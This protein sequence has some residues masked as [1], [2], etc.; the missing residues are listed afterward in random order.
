MIL[1]TR[2]AR[3]GMALCRLLEVHGHSVLHF[4][5]IAFV[6]PVNLESLNSAI[7]NLNNQDC[8]VFNS[9]QAVYAGLELIRKVWPHFPDGSRLIAIGGGTA[10]A[11]HE[12]GCHQVL[13]PEA[14]WHSEGVL[15]LPELQSVKH[16]KIA[17]IR[18]AG[19]RE[20]LDKVLAERGAE[21]LPVIVYE[22]VLPKASTAHLVECLKQHKIQMIVC[23]S[24]ESVKNLKILV[25]DT[26][27]PDLMICPLIVMS[28]R[29][30]TL[31]HDLGFQTIWVTRE[32]S[33]ETILEVIND[34]SNK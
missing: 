3:Q 17:I 18:G 12:S 28:E 27:W 5:T 7:T 24:F 15:S 22:R 10:K 25:D 33:D 34:K 21:V 19:G 23:T 1:V 6:P 31:A 16:K 29:I 2:P 14:S 11:L 4:P 8:L 30:K 13:V 26:V 20:L 9:P 32:A